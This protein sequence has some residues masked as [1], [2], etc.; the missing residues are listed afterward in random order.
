MSESPVHI[1]G[2]PL[3]RLLSPGALTRSHY[4][5]HHLVAA[6]W[7]TGAVNRSIATTEPAMMSRVTDEPRTPP[8]PVYIKALYERT[9]DIARQVV[10]LQLHAANELANGADRRLRVVR[11]NGKGLIVTADLDPRRINIETEGDIVV[12]ASVG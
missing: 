5:S 1:G 10:G 4:E 6:A 12:R 9:Q 8:W 7:T 11:R 3:P 2:P